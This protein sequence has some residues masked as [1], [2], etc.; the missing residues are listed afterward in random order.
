[1]KQ[2]CSRKEILLILL[3]LLPLFF[4]LASHV[5]ALTT[6]V[7]TVSSFHLGEFNVGQGLAFQSD[8][9]LFI[10]VTEGVLNGSSATISLWDRKGK[11]SFVAVNNAKI[12]LSCDTE[13]PFGLSVNGAES[14]SQIVNQTFQANIHSGNNVVISWY[15]RLPSVIDDY[16]MLGIGLG[17][18]VMMIFAP[19][20]VALK[21]KKSGMDADSI[22]RIGYGMLIFVFG[23]GMFLIWVLE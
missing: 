7:Y 20:W 14:F 17:G 4:A 15:Y 6:V 19:S 23:F 16:T 13:N 3:L 8:N 18:L 22:E 1:L 9:T 21:I 10:E 12:K 2:R 5:K 11:L